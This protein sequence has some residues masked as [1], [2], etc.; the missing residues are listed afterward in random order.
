MSVARTASSLARRWQRGLRAVPESLRAR[1]L[2]TRSGAASATCSSSRRRAST[3]RLTI[4]LGVL[5]PARDRS[6][7][8]VHAGYP[9]WRI[10]ALAGLYVVFALAHK[11]IAHAGRARPQ[12]RRDR[13]HRM[14]IVAQLFVVGSRRAHRR[15]P[16][17]VPAGHWC[18]RRSSRCCSSARYA[19]RRAGSRSATACSI[20]AMV[21]AARRGRRPAAAD[22]ATTRSRS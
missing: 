18:C 12:K 14:N 6:A 11:L 3:S 22:R 5:R 4:G 9:T 8:F 21:L 16:L 17:A 13:V 1:R 20:V 2:P 15:R 7:I 10:V 19:G